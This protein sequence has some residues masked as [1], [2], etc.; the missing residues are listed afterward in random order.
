M[1]LLPEKVAFLVD[2]CTAFWSATLLLHRL[3]FPKKTGL[4]IRESSILAA[5]PAGPAHLLFEKDGLNTWASLKDI[6]I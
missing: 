6:L 3:E 1:R 4:G 2:L 5:C